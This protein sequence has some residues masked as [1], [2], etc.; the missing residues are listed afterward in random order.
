MTPLF[1]EGTENIYNYFRWD[2]V[3]EHTETFLMVYNRY[4]KIN[5]FNPTSHNAEV[6]IIW[7]FRRVVQRPKFCQV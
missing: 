7:H 4:R 6:L 2:N 1:R 5:S 3:T